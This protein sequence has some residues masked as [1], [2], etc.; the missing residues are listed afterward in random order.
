MEAG[1]RWSAH[2][3]SCSQATHFF[4]TCC[5]TQPLRIRSYRYSR[6]LPTKEQI[7]KGVRNVIQLRFRANGDIELSATRIGHLS[8]VPVGL[9]NPVVMLFRTATAPPA[10]Y[11]T[12]YSG[13]VFSIASWWRSMFLEPTSI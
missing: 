11:G 5:W 3:W 9:D 8:V 6:S 4:L 10:I 12:A 1:G 13:Q 7:L 2:A